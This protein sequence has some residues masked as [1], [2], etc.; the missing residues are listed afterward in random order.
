MIRIQQVENGDIVF[1]E[2]ENPDE[3]ASDVAENEDA[4][5]NENEDQDEEQNEGAVPGGDMGVAALYNTADEDDASSDSSN[6]DTDEVDEI[7]HRMPGG[8]GDENQVANPSMLLGEALDFDLSINDDES[9]EEDSHVEAGV[10]SDSPD[11]HVLIGTDPFNVD[12]Y[13]PAVHFPPGLNLAQY[14]ELRS[15]INEQ[16]QAH[17]SFL[18]TTETTSKDEAEP[19][20]IDQRGW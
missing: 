2:E 1:R 13:D 4:Q 5:E 17:S 16:D 14:S 8:F 20:D 6:S 3:N 11:G 15:T 19:M 12:V 18:A 7:Y 9:D 10:N